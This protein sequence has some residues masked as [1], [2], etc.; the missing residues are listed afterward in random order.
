MEV[1]MV[2]ELSPKQKAIRQRALQLAKAAGRSWKDL[3]KDE[4][5]TFLQSARTSDR[6]HIA[7]SAAASEGREWDKLSKEERRKY[8][9]QSREPKA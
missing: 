1:R 3:P 5:R 6:K 7:K 4:R 9:S 8:L 2:K